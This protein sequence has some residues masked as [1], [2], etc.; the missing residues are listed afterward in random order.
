LDVFATAYLDDILIYSNSLSEHYRHVRSVL[1]A[2]Q[3]AGLHLKPE[4]CSFY[5]QCVKYLGLIISNNGVEIDPDKVVAITE[6]PTPSRLKE[7]PGFLGFA[8]FY[9]RFILGYSKIV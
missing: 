8:N 2:L 1:S 6:W 3:E 9:H 5:Q 4:K 7:C